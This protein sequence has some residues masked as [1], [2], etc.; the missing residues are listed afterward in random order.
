MPKIRLTDSKVKSLPHPASGRVEYAD[1]LVTGLRLRVGEKTKAWIVRARVKSKVINKTIGRYPDK[2]LADARKAA[3]AYLQDAAETG[4]VKPAST[5]DDLLE[6]FIKDQREK[7][8]AKSWPLQERRLQ[9]HALPHWTGKKIDSITRADVI[10]VVEQIAD[11]G[12][13]VAANRV[14]T[15]LKTMFRFAIRKGLLDTNPADAVEKPGK[16]TARDRW[17]TEDEIKAIWKACGVQGYPFGPFVRF[18][19]LTGQRRTEVA[20][21]KWEDI[22]LDKGEWI[23]PAEN[24]KAARQ[25]LVPLSPPAVDL[26]KD[27]PHWG[28]YAFTSDGETH[29]K[30]YSKL[31]S[32]L[33]TFITASGSALDDWRLHDLRRTMAT[34]MTRLGISEFIVGKVLSHAVGQGVTARHYNIYSYADEKRHALNVWGS[35]L[36]QTVGEKRAGDNVVRLAEGG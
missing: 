24:T 29:I 31:K 34:H 7:Q 32:R 36:L 26:L 16:E 12:A 28:P 21:M 27:L 25:H 35:D 13:E 3:Q 33:D 14:L 20:S 18:L 10:A 6:S 11:T 2:S 30:G 17:L 8:K 23:L 19:L 22:N 5:F 9:I 4:Q 15:T 1:D